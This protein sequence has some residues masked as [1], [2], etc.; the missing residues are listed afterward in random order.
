MSKYDDNGNPCSVN[1]ACVLLEE[2][3]K[4]SALIRKKANR[5]ENERKINLLKSAIEIH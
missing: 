2:L 3:H 4:L 1:T 5:E